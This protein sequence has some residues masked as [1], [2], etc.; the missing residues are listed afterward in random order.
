MGYDIK[1]L[2]DDHHIEKRD[3]KVLDQITNYLSNNHDAM[4][5]G[6]YKK[7]VVFGTTT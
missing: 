4:L 2:F 7:F 1:Q 3:Q 5:D 6:I